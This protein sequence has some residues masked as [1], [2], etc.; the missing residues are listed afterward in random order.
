[1]PVVAAVIMVETIDPTFARVL[2][3]KL[4]SVIKGA[5]LGA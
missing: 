3:V 1:V 5:L 2:P 4:S